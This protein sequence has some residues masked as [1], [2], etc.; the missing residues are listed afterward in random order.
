M[1]ARD[2][3]RG[4]TVT[5][6]GWLFGIAQHKLADYRRRGAAEAPMRARLGIEPVPV[7]AED[8]EMIRWL[9]EDVAAQMVE[10]LPEEQREAVRARARGT[11]I[12]RHRAE[13]PA[14]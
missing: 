2:R 9:G 4:G 7:G 11:G 6:A 14:E 10:D 1:I 12:R 3:Y 5:A 13:R 8:V